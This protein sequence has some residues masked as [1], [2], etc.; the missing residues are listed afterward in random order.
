M[1]IKHLKGF[2]CVWTDKVW[3]VLY[4]T[5][6]MSEELSHSIATVKVPTEP[7]KPSL[8]FKWQHCIRQATYIVDYSE[9]FG[10][11][12]F[13]LQPKNREAKKLK[14]KLME[15]IIYCV[16]FITSIFFFFCFLWLLELNF[17]QVKKNQTD[18]KQPKNP[19]K[20]LIQQC[21]KFSINFSYICLEKKA[22][23]TLWFT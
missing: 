8:L 6:M 4:R 9:F 14:K 21:D 22:S 5:C 10:A 1:C 23:L 17:V 2:I 15:T 20:T 7:R 19:P 11:L 12:L 16:N 18:K 13:E 3:L